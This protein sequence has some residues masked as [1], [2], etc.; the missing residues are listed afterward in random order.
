MGRVMVVLPDVEALR[1]VAGALGF[2]SA[3]KRQVF[4]GVHH[5][6]PG[7]PDLGRFDG[8]YA[9]LSVARLP[10]PED[11]GWQALAATVRRGLDSPA[12]VNPW[13]RTLLGIDRAIPPSRSALALVERHAP[14]A[15]VVVRLPG[16]AHCD[17]LRAARQL[18]VPSIFLALRPDDIARGRLAVDVPDCVAVWNRAHRRE[19]ADQ[20]IPVRRTVMVGAH[21]WT[22]VLEPRA[23][24]PREEYRQRLGIE[25]GRRLVVVA[26]PAQPA[27]ALTQ[28]FAAWH[29][30]RAASSDPGVRQA[31]VV[32]FAGAGASAAGDLAVPNATAVIR[33]GSDF[34]DQYRLRT[35]VARRA[36]ERRRRGDGGCS[37]CPR[38][39][40]AGAAGARGLGRRPRPRLPRGGRACAERVAMGGRFAVRVCSRAGPRGGRR[41]SYGRSG[42]GSRSRAAARRRPRAGRP[43]GPR[44]E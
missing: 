6:P 15:L 1:Q 37:A 4:V 19:A 3:R 27:G 28:W 11:D 30:A 13:T 12:V 42:R 31:A 20:G 8:A 44:R 24:M 25:A 33:A 22:D 16:G 2:L 26:P 5:D 34:A 35:R 7:A 40:R 38:G 32:V 36:G 29:A 14:D 18:S 39:L 21:L 43:P 41:P 10:N 17:Y 23:P 9:G